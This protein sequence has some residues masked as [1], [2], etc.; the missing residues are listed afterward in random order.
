MNGIHAEIL[1]AAVNLI[2]FF[3]FSSYKLQERKNFIIIPELDPWN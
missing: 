2:Y 1:R 3:I